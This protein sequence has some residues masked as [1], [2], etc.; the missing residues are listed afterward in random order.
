MNRILILP[1][2]L[3]GFLI[4]VDEFIFHRRRGLPKWEK[5][6][7]PLDTLTF[8]LPLSLAVFFSFKPELTVT[9]LCLSVFSSL[10]VTKDE[11]LHARICEPG[12][13]WLHSL[14]FVVHPVSFFSIFWLWKTHQHML[15]V[16]LHLGLVVVFLIYQ[17]LSGSGLWAQ[18]FSS[19]QK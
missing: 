2:L 19:L 4:A 8:I 9:F 12:E 14:L 1:L 18:R 13:H 11:F 7:H 6:G 16:R 3:Q 17:I 10:F 15:F 5:W